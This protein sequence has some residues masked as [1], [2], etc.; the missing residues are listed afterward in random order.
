MRLIRVPSRIRKKPKR[1]R[2]CLAALLAGALAV[3]GLAAAGPMAPPAAAAPA[4]AT[5]GNATGLTRSGNTFTVST[6][7]SAKARVVVARTDIFR[8][9]LSPD[10]SFTNDPAG[11]DLAPT[12]DFGSVDTAFTDA[13][14][15]YRITTG[16]LNIRVNKAP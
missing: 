16:A 3:A 15:Y 10:G 4:P 6:T 14:A 8:L 5:A 11:S 1:Q 9:W 13:G 7:G 2:A 12:T